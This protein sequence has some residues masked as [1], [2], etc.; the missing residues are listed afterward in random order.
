MTP[1]FDL[2]K[3]AVPVAGDGN[4]VALDGK[5]LAIEAAIEL[6]GA[7]GAGRCPT[8]NGR[9]RRLRDLPRADEEAPRSR[10]DAS[11]AWKVHANLTAGE[12]DAFVEGVGT[13][14]GRP[15]GLAPFAPYEYAA[16]RRWVRV[17]R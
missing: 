1:S 6:G 9:A 13:D 14:D 10:S 15:D 12:R 3:N 17:Q 16:A 8:P 11:R 5:V 4:L 7:L 2:T